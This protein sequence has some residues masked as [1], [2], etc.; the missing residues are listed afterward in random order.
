M[1]SH[2]SSP[3]LEELPH[4]RHGFFTKSDKDFSLYQ[5]EVRQ[6]LH[7]QKLITAR[8]IHSAIVLDSDRD[9]DGG[10]NHQPRPLEGDALVS[11]SKGKALGIITADCAPILLASLDKP[12]IAVAHAGWRGAVLGIT[13]RVLS[14]MAQK[15]AHHIIA[16]I[17]PHIGGDI[18]QIGADMR[19]TSIAQDPKAQDFFSHHHRQAG[20]EKW[21]F[22]LGGYLKA[23]MLAFRYPQLK[24]DRVERLCFCTFE[25][26]DLFFSYRYAQKHHLQKKG[27][28]LSALLL[29]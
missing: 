10:Q 23:R 2:L 13:D 28:Q 24:V 5:E 17:G 15:G 16:A 18:Y 4:I 26:P 21:M 12:M 3:L 22:D 27:R 1:I 29:R 9:S 7:A 6:S 11:T 20:E 8:Q 19:A 14:L 25:R